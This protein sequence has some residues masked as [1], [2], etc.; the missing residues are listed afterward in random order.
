MKAIVG[1]G[2]RWAQVS[3]LL[4]LSAGGAAGCKQPPA[5]AAVE[6]EP[7]A[8]IRVDA[9]REDLVFSYFDPK[10]GR[11]ESASRIA[12]IPEGL[13]RN[14]VVVDLSLSPEQR[15]AS[16]YVAL[17][18]L[19]EPRPDGSYAVALASRFG[20]ET[21]AAATSSTSVPAEASPAVVLYSASWC[22]VCKKA[23]RYLDSLRVPYVE[24][25]VEASRRAAEEL[26]QKAQRAGIRPGGV[27]V[28]D[29]GGVLLQGFE[30]T[31]LR[32]ALEARGLL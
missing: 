17:V 6:P 20:F 16:R 5:P 3:Y 23:K 10:L 13:R 27:P 7:P 1:R 9:T 32:R 29:V 31:S 4:L 25:D 8:P 26:A 19:T 12:D 22:G 15:G 30:E 21:S 2:R 11:F 24:K 18:D 28:I 14:V